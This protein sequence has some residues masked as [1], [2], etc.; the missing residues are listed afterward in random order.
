MDVKVV[1]KTKAYYD[2]FDSI[3]RK[4]EEQETSSVVQEI[5]ELV[6]ENRKIIAQMKEEEDV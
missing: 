2:N 4:D 3:F 5:H 6:Q 1:P